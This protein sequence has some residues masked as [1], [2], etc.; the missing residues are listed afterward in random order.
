LRGHLYGETMTK[1]E[2]EALGI[3]ADAYR[4]FTPEPAAG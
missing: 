2:A 4:P 1:A 3:D